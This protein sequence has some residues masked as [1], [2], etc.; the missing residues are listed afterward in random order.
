MGNV[1]RSATFLSYGEGTNQ[2]VKG[3]WQVQVRGDLLLPQDQGQGQRGRFI[4][5]SVL[6][7]RHWRNLG[8]V[9]FGLQCN[10]LFRARDDDRT[11]QQRNSHFMVCVGGAE[12]K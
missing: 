3:R 10:Y 6:V 11:P 7:R 2:G 5:S 4:T 9:G 8:I 1:P 12:I